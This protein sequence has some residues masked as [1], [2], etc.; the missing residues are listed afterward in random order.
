MQT[1]TIELTSYKSLKALKDLEQKNLIKIHQNDSFALSG[2]EISEDQFKDWVN[3]A[4]G[5]ESLS[6][7]EAKRQWES[8][9]KILQGPI[10]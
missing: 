8:H 4:E 1:L 5:A 7:N 2:K 9:K 3:E 6:V 10:D